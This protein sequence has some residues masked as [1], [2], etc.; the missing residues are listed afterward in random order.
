MEM[1]IPDEFE[2]SWE[3]PDGITHKE[4]IPVRT[5]LPSSPKGKVVSFVITLDHVEAYLAVRTPSGDNRERFY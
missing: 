4:N 3:S 1:T 5:R 2:I